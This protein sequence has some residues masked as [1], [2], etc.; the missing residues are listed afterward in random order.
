MKK[1]KDFNPSTIARD[2]LRQLSSLKLPPT[3]DNYHK[4]YNQIAGNSSNSMSPGTRKLL[5]EL[6]TEFPRHTQPFLNFANRLEK[7]TNEDNWLEYKKTIMKVIEV[8]TNSVSDAANH[9]EM[10]PVAEHKEIQPEAEID[11][12]NTI[13]TLLKLL[14][15][16]HDTLTIARKREGLN[17]VLGKFTSDSRQ[18]HLKLQALMS[19]W[20]V[21][22]STTNEAIEVEINPSASVS[23]D[24][25]LLLSSQS[26]LDG[27]EDSSAQIPLPQ[28][29]SENN[30]TKQLLELLV[31][32]LDR[33]ATIPHDDA[34]LAAEAKEL[35]A[36]ALIIQKDYE[37]EQFISSFKQ[38]CVK[39]ESCDRL[40]IKLQHSLLMLLNLLLDSTR[41]S[42]SNDQWVK[43]QLDRLQV[44][45]SE[46]LNQSILA[47]AE[48]SVREILSRQKL[49]N[50]GLGEAK[51]TLKQLMSG[52]IS[53][54]DGL[55]E[56]T[57]EYHNKIRGFSEQ[58]SDVDD[59]GKLNQLLVGILLETK[60]MMGN[61][62][63]YQKDFLTARAEVDRAHNKINRLES[64]LQLMG[65][66]VHEDHLTGILN[67]RGLDEAYERETA[68]ANRQNTP[69]CFALLDIDNFKKLN[70]TH[71]HKIGD[72][73]LIYLVE[74]V[75][76]TTRS[77]DVVARYGGEEFV[78][79][80]PN[81]DI[82]EAV[83]I[84]SRIRRN[85]TKKFF[86]HENM[87]L[88]ITFSAGLAKSQPGEQQEQ[89][90]KRADEALYRAKKNGKNQI[91]E[92]L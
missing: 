5:T 53:N 19:S 22:T 43:D 14:E 69:L 32:M 1:H 42:L 90:F 47:Q 46:P 49:I 33:L 24:N 26:N 87:R 21:L 20:T 39:L 45:I 44:I 37:I 71:G 77:E 89:I 30:S 63:D 8:A 34:T 76:H 73:A 92:A 2:T 50:S 78:I 75:K 57:G 41:E 55:S 74:A 18:L 6:A 27:Q 58:I 12:A 28:N 85:L 72:D 62:V 13:G 7:A 66:K 67:R 70:D 84:L 25:S 88:L 56:S 16:K 83:M 60:G 38:F 23:A 82:D 9:K 3:P 40:S 91:L 54:I 86:L 59:V 48:H 79:L 61:I 36:R 68:R 65:E 10:Q 29:Y 31:M 81:T 15:N 51:S 35:A 11:W 4:L 64:E 80:L 17:R 52:L